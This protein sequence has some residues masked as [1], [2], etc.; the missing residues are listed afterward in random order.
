MLVSQGGGKMISTTFHYGI[1]V[2]NFDKCHR[3]IIYGK[4][5]IPVPLS[6]SLSPTYVREVLD[7]KKGKY[8]KYYES[9]I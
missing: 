1:N 5:N 2:S 9:N 4:I 8:W 7:Y 3:N 6:L